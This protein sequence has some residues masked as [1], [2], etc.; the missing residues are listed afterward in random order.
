MAINSTVINPKYNA[1]IGAAHSKACSD[2]N[3][4]IFLDNALL[5]R[6]ACEL[7]VFAVW[8][9]IWRCINSMDVYF[10]AL[11]IKCGVSSCIIELCDSDGVCCIISQ[12]NRSLEPVAWSRPNHDRLYFCSKIK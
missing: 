6:H 4:S 1:F 8:I 2:E 3:A 9:I 7:V 5:G 10:E 11:S 12:R